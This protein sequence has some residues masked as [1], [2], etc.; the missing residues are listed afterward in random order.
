MKKLF[1]L[2]LS[3]FFLPG[4]VQA[5]EPVEF[6][7]GI[8]AVESAKLLSPGNWDTEGGSRNTATELIENYYG[9]SGDFFQFKRQKGVSP[10][11]SYNVQGFSV[12]HLF[13]D[14]QLPTNKNEKLTFTYY[15]NDIS[16][17]NNNEDFYMWLSS[18][19]DAMYENYDILTE[20]AHSFYD[21]YYEGDDYVVKFAPVKCALVTD[22]TT[23]QDIYKCSSTVEFDLNKF[24]PR[25]E[26]L[27]YYDFL[28][29]GYTSN[30]NFGPASIAFVNN[31]N[32]ERTDIVIPPDP[33]PGEGDEDLSGT[34][35][36]PSIEDGLGDSFFGSFDTDDNGG[37]SSIITAPLVAINAMLD[38][39]CTPMSVTYKDKDIVLPCGQDFWEDAGPIQDYLNFFEGGILVYMIIRSLYKLIERLKDPDDDRVEVMKL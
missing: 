6:Y 36:D 30:S 8:K 37:I 34:I 23:T 31:L 22:I 15:T 1:F 25:G 17:T 26:Q 18:S 16:L 10:L 32:Y 12:Y 19:F 35:T 24:K 28:F 2:V 38:N 11:T 4:L 39:T 9:I 14:L 27:D 33:E 3:F 20:Y 13:E 29:F 21:L 7:S 5:L